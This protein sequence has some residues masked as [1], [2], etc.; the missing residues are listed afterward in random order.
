MK[1]LSPFLSL[2]CFLGLLM[3]TGCSSTHKTT[4]LTTLAPEPETTD[5]LILPLKDS[6]IN[7]PVKIEMKGLSD[8]LNQHFNGLIYH[9]SLIE[10]DNIRL[11]IWKEAPIQL[12]IQD[13]KIKSVLP[14]RAVI[15]YRIGTDKLGFPIYDERDLF[16]NGTVRL[17]SSVKLSNWSFT[18][19]TQI[20]TLVWKENPSIKIL[21]QD[22]S[23]ANLVNP[24]I[25]LF[26]KTIEQQIDASLRESLNFKP[27][28]L[29]A[30]NA[31]RQPQLLSETYES[32]LVIDPKELYITDSQTDDSGLFFGMGIKAHIYTVLGQTPK[33]NNPQPI[34]KPVKEIPDRADVSLLISSTY[35]EAARLILKNFQGQ[36]FGEGKKQVRITEVALWQKA[37]KLV[38]KLH[39]EGS[40]TG[41][42]YLSGYPQFNSVTQEVYFDQLDYVLDT[43]NA[44]LKSADWLASNRMLIAFQQLCRYSLAEQFEELKEN[45]ITY[46]RHYSL[47]PGVYLDGELHSLDFVKFELGT[48]ALSAH[49]LLK[50]KMAVSVSGWEGK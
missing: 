19:Q 31:L 12:S 34:L 24:A 45:L 3:L 6:F 16:L 2:L 35:K 49:L 29:E 9:D 43:K 13:K 15:T 40:V 7:L 47:S 36:S 17:L 42:V 37:G 23:V 26:K 14:L 44:L 11:K 10:D 48:N 39:L 25:G 18:T 38:V 46:T 32:R 1:I 5:T 4:K 50:G 22:I 28:I 41:A 21:G 33:F 20:E 30:V 8:L 27:R